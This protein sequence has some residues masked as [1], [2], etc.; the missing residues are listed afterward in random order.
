MK[1]RDCERDAAEC[2][3]T[4][5]GGMST[6]LGW[7][8]TYDG[9]GNRTDRGNPNSLTEWWHCRTCNRRWSSKTKF[10]ETTYDWEG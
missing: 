6:M 5:L 8:P 10:G 9:D 1:H 3:I 7:S 2:R 4:N